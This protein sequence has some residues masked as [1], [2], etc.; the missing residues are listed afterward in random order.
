MIEI[1]KGEARQI[2]DLIFWHTPSGRPMPEKYRYLARRI[3]CKY[4]ELAT[5]KHHKPLF[6]GWF[7]CG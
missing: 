1:T 5:V 4:P 3:V 6:Y 2:I 7:L